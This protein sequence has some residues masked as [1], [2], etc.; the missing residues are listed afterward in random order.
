M[1]IFF[2]NSFESSQPLPGRYRSEYTFF[3]FTYNLSHLR[4]KVLQS[5][6][7]SQMI[8]ETWVRNN[9]KVRQFKERSSTLPYNS[10]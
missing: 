4:L 3:L 1:I 9:G 5:Y 6:Q 8:W 10:V 2:I 7:W